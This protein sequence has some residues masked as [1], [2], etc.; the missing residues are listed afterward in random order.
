MIVLEIVGALFVGLGLVTMT[1]AAI[2]ALRY[3]DTF[4]RLHSAGKGVVLGGVSVLAGSIG[5]GD[6]ALVARA[7][8]V[9]ACL[10]LTAAVSAHAIALATHRAGDPE[11]G[12]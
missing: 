12:S 8:L 7:A 5:T 1:V 10:L 9:A 4:M 3:D 6:P 2:G 11:D